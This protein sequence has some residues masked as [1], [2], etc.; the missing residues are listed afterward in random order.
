MRANA[1]AVARTHPRQLS[2]GVPAASVPSDDLSAC[3][4][5]PT[6]GRMGTEY[7]SETRSRVLLN[8]TAMDSSRAIPV[9]ETWGNS[10]GTDYRRKKA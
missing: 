2:R 8:A 6:Q 9:Y 3:L 1:F 5:G 4:G 7:R 10:C